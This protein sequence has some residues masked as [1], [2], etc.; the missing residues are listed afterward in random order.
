MIEKQVLFVSW[1]G[2]LG[3]ITRNLAVISALRRM[4]PQIEVHWLSNQLAS[5]ALLHAGE[6]ILSESAG[7][8]DYNA[9]L[10]Q[11]VS[12]YSLNVA[13]YMIATQ[14]HWE[15][16]IE[17]F[18]EVIRKYRFDIIIGDEIYELVD[19]LAKGRIYIEPPL[20][21][22]DDFIVMLA[23]SNKRV[24]QVAV[25]RSNRLLI[26]QASILKDKVTRFFIGELGDVPEEAF[27]SPPISK[28]EFVETYYHIIGYIIRFDPKNYQ[29]RDSIKTRLGYGK[30]PL[31]V[32][33]TGGT[34]AGKELLELCGKAFLILKQVIKDL[35]MVCV[36]GESYGGLPPELPSG[37]ELYSYVEE[38]YEH[39][40]ACDMAIVVGGGTTT[41][42]LTALQRPF[43]FF[44]LEKQFDQ[45]IYISRRLE[46][47]GAGIRMTYNNTSPEKLSDEILQNMTRRATWQPIPTDG[48]ENA[49][50][51]I[52]ESLA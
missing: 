45:Q 31:L 28:R 48:A 46:R 11:I 32:C 14:R 34:A 15:K 12:G 4:R 47:H 52:S 5:K 42:E 13:E 18:S 36:Y 51:I 27:G 29:D 44:P 20:F 37:I 17:L 24:E 10:P 21:V 38:L 43:V 2:G 40:A 6:T 39:F 26:Q 30:A 33:A 50:R 19:A 49:A 35:R 7:I 3:H 16:N 41:I 1:Q 23:M 25:Q 8:A 9:F 22:F